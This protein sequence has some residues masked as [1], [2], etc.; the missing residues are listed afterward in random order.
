MIADSII[1]ERP[2]DMR[3]YDRG[4]I[5]ERYSPLLPSKSTTWERAFVNKV[6]KPNKTRDTLKLVLEKMTAEDMVI[7]RVIPEKIGDMANL[8]LTSGIFDFACPKLLRLDLIESGGFLLSYPRFKDD[9]EYSLKISNAVSEILR[10]SIF[11]LERYFEPGSSDSLK[12]WKKA[13]SDYIS[14]FFVFSD[15]ELEKPFSEFREGV[16]VYKK[17]FD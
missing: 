11:L 6:L 3:K 12:V 1:F 15:I 13:V 5:L 4:Q 10:M 14:L 17:L 8:Y 2:F 16:R 9:P 7:I